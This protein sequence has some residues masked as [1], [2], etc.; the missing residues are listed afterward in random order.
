MDKQTQQNL[1]ALVKKS[2]EDIAEEFDTTRQKHLWPELL[3]LA[4]Q[5][6]DGQSVLDVGC[7]NGRLVEAFKEKAVYYLGVDSNKKLIESAKTRWLPN[8]ECR[9]CLPVGKVSNVEFKLGDILELDK[10]EEKDFD[11]VFCVAVLHHLPG[12]DLR[13]QALKQLKEKLKPNGKIILTVWNLWSQPKFRKLIFKFS[14]LKLFGRNRR[15]GGASKIDFGDILFSWKNNLGV[16]I[17]QRYY[18]AFTKAGLKKVVR[19]AKLKIEQLYQDKYNY[20]LI[21][22]K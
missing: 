7:G 18:Y 5:V 21:L 12:V 4:G 10:I 2:Y 11:Y 3:K 22:R 9:T 14:I 8:V 17:S 1:L 20:Y 6:K 19:K 13:V 15:L 16:E